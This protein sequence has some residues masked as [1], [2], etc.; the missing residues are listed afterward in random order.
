M[1]DEVFLETIRQNPEDDA[2]RLVYADWLE[3]QG[4]IRAEFLRLEV[5]WAHEKAAKT[6]TPISKRMEKLRAEIDPN[7][8]AWIE[9]TNRMSVYWPAD[10]C[11]ILAERGEMG[12]PLRF[13]SVSGA[14][15]SAAI[16]LPK[17]RGLRRGDYIYPVTVRQRRL[18]V[19]ARMRIRELAA[20]AA[21]VTASPEEASLVVDPRLG[22]IMIGHGGTVQRLD[23]VL[24]AAAV[25]RLRFWRSSGERGLKYLKHG[26]LEHS[27][28]LQG[29]FRITQRTAMDFER[30][31]AGLPFPDLP[32]EEANLF[33]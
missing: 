26:E 10:L 9:R 13:V 17:M 20:A 4:D 1:N 5:Q 22:E 6:K 33:A 18:H 7:W 31:L 32:P 21:F 2:P 12:R 28:D 25:S 29:I 14:Y 11:R 15:G 30:L 16:S 19:I 8:V 24:P 3:E 27:V 23:R